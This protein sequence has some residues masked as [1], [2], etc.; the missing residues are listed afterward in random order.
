MHTPCHPESE[1]RPPKS[2]SNIAIIDGVSGIFAN[3]ANSTVYASVSNTMIWRQI[4]RHLQTTMFKSIF[5]YVIGFFLFNIT[6]IC[7]GIIGAQKA[8]FRTD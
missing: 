7:F 8:S 4:E 1:P 6:E 3:P 2:D 5:P